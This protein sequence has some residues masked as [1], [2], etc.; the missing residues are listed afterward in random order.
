MREAVYWR[1]QEDYVIVLWQFGRFGITEQEASAF[2]SKA[3][4]GYE[5]IEPA[6]LS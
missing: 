5:S 2:L 6:K 3:V 1:D 4:L